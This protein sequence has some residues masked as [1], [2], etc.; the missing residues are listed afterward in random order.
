MK[1]FVGVGFEESFSSAVD[2]WLKKVRK[3]ADQKNLEVNWTPSAN[4]HVTLAFL[5][6]TKESEL[7]E[8]ETK[9]LESAYQHQAFELKIRGVGTFPSI[10]QARVLWLGCQR[11]QAL[12]N[13]QSDLENRLFTQPPQAAHGREQE[14]T[15]HLTFARLRNPKGCRDLLSPFTHADFGRQL[16]SEII[17]FNSVQS[18]NFVVYKPVRRFALQS[19][20]LD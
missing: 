8:L 15:P 4:L 14:F 6:P 2:L 16:V 7:P 10:E 18:G 5:G 9:L 3:G 19:Q 13:L 11:S 17:L 12:L 20:S 1:L